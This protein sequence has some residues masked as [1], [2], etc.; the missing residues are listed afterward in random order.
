MSKRNSNI[1][2]IGSEADLK[3]GS[4]CD[5]RLRTPGIPAGTMQ[6]TG[7]EALLQRKA[8]PPELFEKNVAG[9]KIDMIGSSAEL[10]PTSSHQQGWDSHDTP[11][12]LETVVGEKGDT[13]RSPE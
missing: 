1:D 10:A 4:P 9:G 11:L 5:V 12:S 6:M 7:S 3:Y 8:D 2:M 13:F